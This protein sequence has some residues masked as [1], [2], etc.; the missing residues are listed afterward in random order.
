M[1]ELAIEPLELVIAAVQTALEGVGVGMDGSGLLG[2]FGSLFHL[3]FPG[4]F[5][6]LF[7]LGFLGLFGRLFG[8]GFLGL[9]DG[10]L[11]LGRLDRFDDLF[12]LEKNRCRLLRRSFRRLGRSGLDG[13]F[14][15]F[16]GGELTHRD[17]DGGDLQPAVPLVGLADAPG[18]GGDDA[19]ILKPVHIKGLLTE[20]PP[21]WAWR[22]WL[23]CGSRSPRQRGWQRPGS[24]PTPGWSGPPGA[25]RP[26]RP[27]G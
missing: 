15:V 18:A 6:S 19:P 5:D 2:L 9:F 21:G 26:G 23:R 11:S 12:G 8:L 20:F 3:G 14:L 10:L 4:L 13:L 1:V 22:G 24:P 27:G 25:C 7:R 17:G 16:C